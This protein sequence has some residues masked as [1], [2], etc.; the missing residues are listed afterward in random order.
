MPNT[1]IIVESPAKAKTIKTHLGDEFEVLATYG[2]VRNLKTKE[3]AVDVDNDFDV[4]Y[5]LVVKNKKHVTAIAEAINNADTL[6]LATD[7]DREGEAISWH[8]LEILKSKNLLEGKTV[9]RIVFHE[10]TKPAILSAIENPRN[11]SYE[12]INAQQARDALDYLVS[13]SL[14]PLLW[15][16]IRRGLSADR[17]QSSAL[18]MIVE[19]EQEIETFDAK[20]YW[21][22]E[23]DLSAKKQNFS[24]KLIRYQ[25]TDLTQFSVN[26]ADDA[27]AIET[28]LSILTKGKLTV[29]KV[30][31]KQIHRNPAAPFVTSTLLQE[32]SRKL[33][34]TALRTMRVA[35]QLYD[36]ID[37]GN[38]EVGLISYVRTDSTHLSQAAV[39]DIR[40]YIALKYG[41]ESLPELP[42]AYQTKPKNTQ[43]AQGAIRPTSPNIVPTAIKKKLTPEQFKLYELI[44]K[45][46]IACQMISATIDSICLNFDAVQGIFQATGYTVST[47]GFMPVYIEGEDDE[48]EDEDNGRILPTLKEGDK[49]NLLKI[50]REQLFSEPPTRFS[51]ACLVKSLEEHGIGRPSTY[52][53][54]ISTLQNREYVEVDKKRFYPTDVGRVVNKFL[55][56]HFTRYVDYSFTARMEDK[57]DA[58][59]CGEKEW[60]P[61]M[62][63][64]WKP[65]SD[66]VRDKTETVDRKDAT[67]EIINEKC[68]KCSK[69]LSIRLGRL[70]QFI[71]CTTYPECDYTR[72]LGDDKDASNE[73]EVVEGS[74]CPA[75]QSKLIIKQGKFGKFVGCSNYP[76]CK[77]I[78]P[79]EKPDNTGIKCPECKKGSILKRLSR[80]GKVFYSCSGYPGCSY[81]VWNTPIDQKCPECKWPILTVKTSKRNG[82]E[83]V[84]PQKSCKFTEPYK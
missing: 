32:A 64:F 56:R 21:P 75:C 30:E 47:P 17:V 14:S 43:E 60:I 5:Q 58:V 49:V 25:T 33:A 19:R 39:D 46:T 62:H 18:R 68:P 37:T 2:H 9:K 10:I 36:G 31:K 16:K 20:E 44:W 7:P 73:A 53:S 13:S 12:M 52:S 38:G 40:E 61:L 1:L 74:S 48:I 59:S 82:S 45:R 70:G 67:Q 23:A 29:S 50:R 81:A 11:L 35:Q 34:F 22:I 15:K 28:T 83:K 8:L 54:I 66:L 27:D 41:A 76:D 55:T 65:F 24:A 57:L 6:Y 71:G 84:C 42:P 80:H 51:E 77:H 72:N 4:K 63:E 26:N 69:P 79:L 3:S 78:E